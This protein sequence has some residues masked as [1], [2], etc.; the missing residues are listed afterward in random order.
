MSKSTLVVISSPSGGGKDT[1]IS[2]LLKIF[3][4]SAKLVTTTSRKPRTKDIPGFSYNFVSKNDFEKK[5]DNDE[6]LEY[7][8]YDGNYYGIEKKVLADTL[9]KNDFVFTNIDVNGKASLDKNG[10]KHLAIF[11]LPESTEVLKTRIENRGG[12]DEAQI[13][14]RL[15]IAKKE[16]EKAKGYDFRVTNK[17]GQIKKTVAEIERIIRGVDKK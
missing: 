5:I 17:N 4:N 1:I 9:L 2:K 7:N 13:E 3:P 12:L 6:M 10:I 11:L 14:N 16:I 15:K 8:M